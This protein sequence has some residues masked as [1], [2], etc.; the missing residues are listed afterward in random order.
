MSKKKQKKSPKRKV[1]KKSKTSPNAS[2][3]YYSFGG[4]AILLIIIL[5]IY[6]KTISYDFAIDDKLIIVENIYANEGL[7]G[8]GQLIKATFSNDLTVI[9]V[10]RPVTMFS[11]AL[12]VSIFGM[13]PGSHHQMN[14]LYYIILVFLLFNLLRSHL[15]PNHPAWLSFGIVL[16]FTVH[17]VHVE[18][19]ANIKGRDDILC[20]IFGILSMIYFFR[21][22]KEKKILN[23]VLSLTFVI[24]SFLSKETGIIFTI[25]IPLTYYYFS[26]SSF[27][28][29]FASNYSY[30]LIGI[31][32]AGLRLIVFK[33][34]AE[35]F[36]IYNNS[37]FA[38]Q[39]TLSQFA[40]TFRV[41]IHYIQLMILP[42]PLSWDYSLGHF[43]FNNF[44][45][46][47]A[48]ISLVV[49]GGL[50][51]WVITQLKNKNLV[52]FGIA[53]FLIALFPISNILIKIPATFGER[54]LF[55]PSFGFA[56]AFVFLIHKLYNKMATQPNTKTMNPLQLAVLAVS[57][58]F[59]ILSFNRT[60]VWK[61]EDTLIAND[62]DY[63]NS[64]R[65]SRSYIQQLTA[66]PNDKIQN[67]KKALEV[68]TKALNRFEDDWQL[69]YFKGVI[70]RTLNNFDDAK[71]AFQ[72]SI[73]Y[74]EDNLFALASYADL[75][76]NEQPDKAIE[77][78]RKAMAVNP[79]NVIVLSNLGTVLHQ[80]GQL[81]EAKTLYEKVL[82]IDPTN[83]T[84]RNNLNVLNQN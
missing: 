34:E 49:Y 55:I 23:H 20:F 37:L 16:L 7:K 29:A 54:F 30:L 4:Y 40:L 64:L 11:H 59:L 58:V 24:L 63:A 73:K 31:L 75:I 45:N 53:I 47:L 43:E 56:F 71:L 18:S 35:N 28:K 38:V 76:V 14:V 9:G 80:K 79:D 19:V 15:I 22:L 67:H 17:P 61:N 66:L 39:D 78:Y 82:T 48:I 33:D 3:K 51:V 77:L 12:D 65:S 1:A 25:L 81:Q 8:F 68:C 21:N 84:I 27:K 52:S 74:K 36:N 50:T 69:W 42:Y 62:F 5:L 70:E 2:K 72:T 60:E 44:T 6:G 26:D 10:T 46:V 32:L 13:N 83:Q 57:F 41:L